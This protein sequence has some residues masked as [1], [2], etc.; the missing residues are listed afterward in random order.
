M[1]NKVTAA[2]RPAETPQ[3]TELDFRRIEKKEKDLGTVYRRSV[4]KE[5]LKEIRGNPMAIFA[6]VFLLTMIIGALIAPLS[7]YDPN[8]IDLPNKFQ[9][10][11]AQHW[12]GTDEFGRS[13]FTRA[14]YGGRV[15]LTVGFS[16]MFVTICIG[17]VIG[18]FP[19]ISA[20]SWICCSCDLPIFS[21]LCPVCC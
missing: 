9:S 1:E 3:L 5:L 6:C 21:S 16:A 19:V 12:F 20:A 13:Y 8:A 17:A 18:I 7:P 15:S 10:P 2:G 14:L 11:S 4:W